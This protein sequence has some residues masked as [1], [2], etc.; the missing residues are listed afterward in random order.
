MI[1]KSH[2][3][4]LFIWAIVFSVSPVLSFAQKG[5]TIPKTSAADPDSLK[6][7]IIPV[8]SIDPANED[9][10]DLL[11]LAEKIGQSRLVLL[12]EATHQEGTT[13]RAK[14]RLIKFLHQKMVFDVLAL[15][16]GGVLQNYFASASVRNET[17]ALSK[18]GTNGWYFYKKEGAPLFEY[19][20]ASWKTTRPLEIGG[21]EE[22][23]SPALA[24][25]F[26]QHL[27][28]FFERAPRLA[29]T[30][31]EW[32]MV[33]KMT[34]ERS[35]AYISDKKPDESNRLA[36][37]AVL[38]N[39]LHQMISQKAFLK[40]RFSEREL[41]I[42]E[43]FVKDALESEL[44]RHL[45]FAS[46]EWNRER[47]R[48]MAKNVKFLTE[49][50]YPKRKIIVSAAT[51][52]LIRGRNFIRRKNSPAWQIK[53]TGDYLYPFCRNKMYTIAFTTFGGKYGSIEAN[54]ENVNNF[55][56]PPIESF[57]R[58]AGSLN[59]PYLFADLRGA[60]AGHWLKKSFVPVALGRNEDL[61]PWH[62]VMDAFFFIRE[63]EPVEF[64]S[65]K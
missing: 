32:Q 44:Q 64:V 54:G 37:R 9:F 61:A 12:G 41:L 52:H 25:K 51:A 36:E 24:R 18:T 7:L 3:C 65:V 22:G 46:L 58:A 33:D 29:F 26:K 20:R 57:E 53:Q 10:S 4:L 16:G 60:P 59:L 15:E 45:P 30:E 56:Q 27:K 39:L 2:Y 13:D 19:L 35:F 8:K 14:L 1:Y 63:S 42:T 23:R 31:R 34:T 5:K 55:N 28:E 43:Q 40:I 48:Y 49:V 17:F 38:E 21:I 62:M 11:P 47:D 50:L 6:R